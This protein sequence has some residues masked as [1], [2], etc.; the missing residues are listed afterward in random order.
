MKAVIV[1]IRGET[2]AALGRDGSVFKVKNHAYAVGQTIDVRRGGFSRQLAVL[3]AAAAAVFLIVGAGIHTYVS[4]YSI[5]SLDVNPSLQYTLNRLNVVLSVEA[6]NGDGT[7]LLEEVGRL[8]NRSIE[9]AITITVR[10]IAQD[11]YFDGDDPGGMVIAASCRDHQEAERIAENVRETAL[12]ATQESA[13]EVVVAAMTVGEDQI[14]QARQLGVSPGKLTLVE[15]LRD[16][17]SDPDSI[18]MQEWLE[19]P[20]K[21]IMKETASQTPQSQ[22]PASSGETGS[23]PASG[24][25]DGSQSGG[26]SSGETL[27][28]GQ[29]SGESK[30]QDSGK[31][32]PGWA[33][34]AEELVSSGGTPM[35]Y[36]PTPPRPS[37]K[38]PASTA[39]GGGTAS[40]SGAGD[41][42]QTPAPSGDS[43]TGGTTASGSHESGKESAG[44]G[45]TAAG[46]TT[47]GGT[48]GAAGGTSGSASSSPSHEAPVESGGS[49]SGTKPEQT[50]SSEASSSK[51]SSSKSYG[52]PMPPAPDPNVSLPWWEQMD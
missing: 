35:E 9:D 42:T 43:G 46:G 32:D 29:D 28:S 48:S 36:R 38:D 41:D 11:G 12:R 18:D 50:A 10:Q 19:K 6:V 14:E 47:S 52:Y 51:R 3:A 40:G 26:A 22:D 17:A 20:V 13:K 30:W 39:Q 27:P 21:D 1:E 24:E 44:G 2:A 37:R 16:T 33:S 5:V 25:G 8:N 7:E 23:A 15:Q 34:P 49:S 4:P 31:V 45:D